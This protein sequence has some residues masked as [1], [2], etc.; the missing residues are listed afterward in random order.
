MLNEQIHLGMY[1]VA[2][3]GEP[4]GKIKEIHDD[5]FLVDRP[6]KTDIYVPMTDVERVVSAE[7]IVVLKMEKWE[8]DS[9]R[10]DIPPL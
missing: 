4:V 9:T 1:V 3:D 5:N 8:V 10:F 2:L 7:Q 6:L